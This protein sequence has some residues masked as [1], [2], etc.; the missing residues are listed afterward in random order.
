MAIGTPANLESLSA[1]GVACEAGPSD[2][3]I[4]VEGPETALEA[5]ERELNAPAA[6]SSGPA[7]EPPRS[8]TTAA[9]ALPAP[10]SR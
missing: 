8:L 7:E 5:A 4:A 10:T 3:V 1:L 9:R 6:P 2:I